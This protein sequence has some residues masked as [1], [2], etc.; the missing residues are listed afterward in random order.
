M[1]VKLN[2]NGYIGEPAELYNFYPDEASTSLYFE[3]V[4]SDIEG[5]ETTLIVSKQNQN[6]NL[7]TATQPLPKRLWRV[8]E[9]NSQRKI[10]EN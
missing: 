8:E 2:A 5:S 1:Y 9:F 10:K 7:S 3:V 4:D 6:N